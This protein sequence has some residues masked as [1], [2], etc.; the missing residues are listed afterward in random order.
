MKQTLNTHDIYSLVQE[1]QNWEGYRVLNI[2]DINSHTICIKFN[3][4]DSI[5]K[6]LLIESGKKFYFLDKFNSTKDFPSSFSSKLRKHI[7]NK[8]LESTTQINIDRVID[9][10]FGTNEFSFHLIAEFYASGNII[11]T[12]HDYKILTLIHPYTYELD[13]NSKIKVSVGQNYPFEVATKHIDL[14]IDYINKIFTDGIS[15][16]DKKIKLKQLIAKLP[17]IKFSSNVIE[18]AFVSNN[19]DLNKKINSDT[20]LNEIFID[21]NQINNI[22][23]TIYELYN[24][25]KNKLCGYI[26]LDNVYPYPYK[27]IDLTKLTII[28]SFAKAISDYFQKLNPIE[29]IELIKK[30][31]NEIKLSKKEKVIIN[32]RNKIK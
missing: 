19:I 21:E 18:H 4:N 7:N 13:K 3:T 8:R 10:K 17:I 20:K 22:I 2:Y 12:D 26:G 11:L 27:N 31:E 29:T 16:I 28:E 9:L 32:I 14:N 23:A 24:L 30:K 5:K 15:K 25:N 1:L 6:Y